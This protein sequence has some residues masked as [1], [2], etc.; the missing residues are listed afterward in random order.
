M[1]LWEMNILVS[2]CGYNKVGGWWLMIKQW[3]IENMVAITSSWQHLWAVVG[4]VKC[5][6]T[7]RM[8]NSTTSFF[9]AF[10]FRKREP[11]SQASRNTMVTFDLKTALRSHSK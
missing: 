6:Y 7:V 2:T 10:W 3:A 11:A 9:T 5:P 1:S 4:C 8:T